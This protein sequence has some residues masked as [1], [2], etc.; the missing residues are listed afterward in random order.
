MKIPFTSIR[1]PHD[2]YV[3]PQDNQRLPEAEDIEL[4]GIG[5][6]A[7]L[8]ARRTSEILLRCCGKA[9]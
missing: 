2:N 5:H 7:L 1:T 9:N 4:A 3:M 6:L 8:Y